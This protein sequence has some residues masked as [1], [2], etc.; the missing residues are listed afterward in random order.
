MGYTQAESMANAVMDGTV[1]LRDAIVFH[2][3]SNHYPPVPESMAIPCEA[4]IDAYENY[5]YDRL[6][7][8]P[9]GILWRGE[10]EAPA[11]A[12]VEDLHLEAFLSF[13]DAYGED[14]LRDIPE[15]DADDEYDPDI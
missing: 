11:W 1:S 9:D 13:S 6:I 14:D 2:L 15:W 5:E 12:I 4:A 7:P 3:R 8:L 10:P